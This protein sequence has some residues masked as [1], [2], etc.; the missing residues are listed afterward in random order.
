[1]HDLLIEIENI[2]GFADDIV[3]YHSGNRIDEINKKL[4]DNYNLVEKYASDWNKRISVN[5]CESILFR[6]QVDKCNYNV[7]TNWRKFEIGSYITN[8]NFP[9][10]DIVKTFISILN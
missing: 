1:M 2:I 5:K 3:I 7:R 9:T 4:Q 6:P 8:K 10:K